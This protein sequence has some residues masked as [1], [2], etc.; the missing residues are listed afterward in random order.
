MLDNLKF[1]WTDSTFP[2]F[3]KYAVIFL[4]EI[5]FTKAFPNMF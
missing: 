3:M 2:Q 4:K 1:T 5:A